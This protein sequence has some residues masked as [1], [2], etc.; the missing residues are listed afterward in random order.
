MLSAKN[1]RD[2]Q[3]NYGMNSALLRQA[4]PKRKTAAELRKELDFD[5]SFKYE[6]EEA[7]SNID[8][9]PGMKTKVYNKLASAEQG[10]EE[11][12]GAQGI[13]AGREA[14]RRLNDLKGSLESQQEKKLEEMIQQTAQKSSL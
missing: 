1:R 10:W 14:R 4:T 9:I 3:H 11:D 13:V 6:M 2:S 7:I 5:H 12:K 8:R